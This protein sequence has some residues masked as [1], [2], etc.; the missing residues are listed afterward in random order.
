MRLRTGVQD[1]KATR[2]RSIALVHRL[3]DAATGT[4][5]RTRAM[6]MFAAALEMD[7]ATGHTV[8]RK[9]ADAIRD[10]WPN[11][12]GDGSVTDRPLE[13]A[14][15]ALVHRYGDAARQLQ[16]PTPGAHRAPGTAARPRSTGSCSR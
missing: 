6:E 8:H 7:A 10:A 3:C 11:Y 12:Q 13:D 9:L 2:N 1:A 16:G 5:N 14:K 4:R 15:I